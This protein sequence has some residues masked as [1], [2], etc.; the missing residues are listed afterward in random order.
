MKR[1]LVALFLLL[2]SAHLGAQSLRV[3]D[4]LRYFNP[5]GTERVYLKLLPTPWF[6]VRFTPQSHVY[7]VDTAYISFGIN[8][9][10]ATFMATDTL[11]VR[12]YAPGSVL[13]S[14]IDQ[15]RAVIPP[16]LQ[17][18]V[19]D[20]YWITEFDLDGIIPQNSAGSEFW[21]AW[22]ILGPSTNLARIRLKTPALNPQRSVVL[23]ANN[24]PSSLPAYIF[25]QVRDTCDLWAETTVCYPLGV[26]VELSAFDARSTA[27]GVEL[28]WRTDTETNNAG[29]HIERS[30]IVSEDERLTLWETIGFVPGR[31]TTTGASDYRY[32]DESGHL[33]SNENG[34]V[35]YR[36][37][38]VDFDGR[39]SY[40]S[41]R[42]LRIPSSADG[43]TL[44]AVHPHP[45]MGG[46][47]ASIGFTLPADAPARLALY[48]AAGRHVR[49]M[50]DGLTA[51]G[52][53]AVQLDLAGLPSGVYYCTLESNGTRLVRRLSLLP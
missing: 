41:V 50:R 11:H 45:V 46:A 39:H 53:H 22:R 23:N 49:T 19:P 14:V 31:G 10:P 37:R 28:T 38:Q 18:Q 1:L 2:S 20:A 12:L 33:R 17:G 4:T 42:V 43:M 7:T 9:T 5:N 52:S 8:R 25:A 48:D 35:K 51:A 16:N 3:C 13:A 34:V 29:F 36:L 44:D 24:A 47:Q 27:Q 40:S 21:L 15:V 6:A 30:G 32:L 26:P